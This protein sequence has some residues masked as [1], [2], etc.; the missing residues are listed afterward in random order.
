[1]F[2][3]IFIVAMFATAAG[4]CF[5]AESLPQ[6]VTSEVFIP[7]T[8][9]LMKINQFRPTLQQKRKQQRLCQCGQLRVLMRT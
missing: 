1:M 9:R 4:Y 3:K 6:V 5:A 7:K 8:R 2:R